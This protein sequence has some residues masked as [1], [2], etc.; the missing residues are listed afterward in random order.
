MRL[1]TLMSLGLAGVAAAAAAQAPPRQPTAK[2]V[3]DFHASQCV[4]YRTYG[5][6]ADPLHLV[7]KKPPLGEL[8]QLSVMRRGTAAAAAQVPA[9]ISVD[10]GPPLKANMLVFGAKDQKLRIYRFNMPSSGFA[11]VKEAQRLSIRATGLDETFALAQVAPLLKIMDECA[12]DLRKTWNVSDGAGERSA[13]ATRA[14]ANIVK[15][16]SS[17]DYPAVALERGQSGIVSFAL[18]IDEAGRVADCTVM[19]TSGVASLDTQTCSVL[20]ERARFKPA[21]GADGKPVKD[22]MTGRVKWVR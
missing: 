21:T 17:L 1:K 14:T 16:F 8:M 11:A 10:D 5:T 13:L 6:E 19:D 22:A 9:T 2:W 15:L 20:T 7:L 4:A 18:L 3:V 12:A